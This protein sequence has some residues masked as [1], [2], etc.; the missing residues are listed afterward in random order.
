MSHDTYNIEH[1]DT[2]ERSDQTANAKG[3]DH[4]TNV[5][6]VERMEVTTG[7]T[8]PLS[9]K[10]R[11]LKFVRDISWATV[12]LFSLIIMV[13]VIVD[14]NH[15]E[16]DFL[17]ETSANRTRIEQLSNQLSEQTAGTAE[18]LACGRKYQDVFDQA[19]AKAQIDFND[20]LIVL[21][22]TQSQTPEREAQSKAA[23]DRIDQDNQAL[24]TALAEKIDYNNKDNPLPCPIGD[25]ETTTTSP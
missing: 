14:K 21:A 13:L 24:E 10:G 16:A 12:I 11:A 6:T 25:T 4:A 8:P 17:S 22:S 23:I 19:Q 20:L 15:K 18:K 3:V 2:V 9:P 7:G 1:A 5:G